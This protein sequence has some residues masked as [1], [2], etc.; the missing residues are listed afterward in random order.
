[1]A[2]TEDFEAAQHRSRE[3]LERPNNEELLNLYALYK[4]ATDG[5][6]NTPEPEM[7][8]LKAKFKWKQWQDK[9]GMNKDE[10]MRQYVALVD[11]LWGKY[12]HS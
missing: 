1:M 4:Q 2:L 7:F 5:D 6:N 10:A 8:D 11:S 12:N 3:L 9:G